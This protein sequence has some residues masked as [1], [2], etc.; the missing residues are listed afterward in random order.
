MATVHPEPRPKRDCVCKRARHQHGTRAAYTKDGCRCFPC[1]IA[2]SRIHA[3][4]SAGH[5]YSEGLLVP[6]CS[7]TRR[8]EALHAVGWSETAIAARLGVTKQAVNDL[9]THPGQHV[10]VETAADIAAVYDELWNQQATG[11]T[12]N[13]TRN[14]A[15]GKG[16]APPLAWDDDRI[17]DPSASPMLDAAPVDAVDE[18]AVQRLMAGTM[19][20]VPFV[21]ATP[22]LLEAVRRLTLHGFSDRE[23]G[24]RVGLK[25]DAVGAMRRR[26]GITTGRAA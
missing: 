20:A 22:E 25:P 4:A 24:S 10:T 15:A 21:N 17:D 13:R 3:Q 1:R 16:F 23:I 6:R 7:V 5:G 9:R 2:N 19:R 18:V 11:R 8:L 26:H 14:W 12:V